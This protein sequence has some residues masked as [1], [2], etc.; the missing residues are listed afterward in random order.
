METSQ[1]RTVQSSPIFFYGVTNYSEFV[2]FLQSQ[3]VANY[4]HKETNSG[5][6]LTTTTTDQ[7]RKLRQVLRHKYNVQTGKEFFGQL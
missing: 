2:K 5:L 4:L 1:V 6:I 3:E 7:Y